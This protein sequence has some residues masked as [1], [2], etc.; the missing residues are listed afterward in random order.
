M[1]I[2][3]VSLLIAVTAALVCA[4]AASAQVNIA[5][6]AT[7]TGSA[8][9][10]G[11]VPARLIDGDYRY[12]YTSATG[13]Y[14]SPGGTWFEL[15]WAADVTFDTVKLFNTG[16][17]GY[18]QYNLSK[19]DIS[20]W[21]STTSAWQIVDS[22]DYTSSNAPDVYVFTSATALTTDKIRIDVQAQN[23]VA[24]DTMLRMRE[25]EVISAP[26]PEPMTLSLLAM[27]GLGI[28]SRRR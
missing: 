26:V 20:I 15:A 23:N 28:L 5:P 2:K 22:A 25:M 9:W 4:Q 13:A 11:N 3:S 12:D 1:R 17:T 21:N 6:D 18:A 8:P 7:A 10:N 14:M 16:L 24:G 27:G 19:F